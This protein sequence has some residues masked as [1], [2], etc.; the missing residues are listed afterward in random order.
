MCIHVLGHLSTMYIHVNNNYETRGGFQRRWM[1][2]A[3]A[4]VEMVCF[5]VMV[6]VMVKIWGVGAEGIYMHGFC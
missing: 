3:Y 6:F 2:R 1:L 5:V 4:V